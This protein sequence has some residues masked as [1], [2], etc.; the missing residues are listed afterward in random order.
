MVEV[1]KSIQK[2]KI[3]LI[4]EVHFVSE[5]RYGQLLPLTTHQQRR[6]FQRIYYQLR[7]VPIIVKHKRVKMSIVLVCEYHVIGYKS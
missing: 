6:C 1:I 2:C 5:I 4:S 3:S 7:L